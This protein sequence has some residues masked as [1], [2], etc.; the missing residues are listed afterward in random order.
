MKYASWLLKLNVIIRPAKVCRKLW[1]PL[2]IVQLVPKSVVPQDTYQKEHHEHRAGTEHVPKPQH[3]LTAKHKQ[4]H[5]TI[6]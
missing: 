1:N 2:R 4:T 5:H 6:G 3:I